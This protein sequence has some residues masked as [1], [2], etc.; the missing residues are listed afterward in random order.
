MKKYM[1]RKVNVVQPDGSYK[2]QTVYGHSKKEL[3]QKQARLLSDATKV[4]ERL[5]NPTFS[6][7][8]DQWNAAHEAEVAHYTYDCYQAPLRDLQ[9]AFGQQLIKDITSLE[10]QRFL[11]DMGKKGYAKH[12]IA[13]RKIV[14]AQIFDYAVL[15]GVLSANPTTVTKIPKGAPK[16]PRALP[17][18]ADI[19][20]V[21][22]SVDVSFGLFAYLILYTGCRRGEALALRY[23]DIDREANLI[24]ISKVVVYEYGKP[25]ICHRTK[26]DSGI[27]TIPLLAPLKNALP[28][29]SGYIFSRNGQ[30]LTLSQFNSQWR[31]YRKATG[32]TLTPHQLRHAFATICFDADLSAKDAAQLL[33]HSK[34]ELTMDVYTHIRQSR[35][36]R[37]AEQ[38]NAFVSS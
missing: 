18:E 35:A 12:T 30:P 17:N 5:I 34:V 33:G 6:A 7:I 3:D 21:K 9:A 24:H 25:T 29:G 19:E 31:A 14:A 37:T 11:N 27:R 38:L 2:R 8:S 23:E 10:L 1:Q 20:K 13:L 15:Q 32:V 4:R 26:S 28:P 16:T 36:Q 22:Q